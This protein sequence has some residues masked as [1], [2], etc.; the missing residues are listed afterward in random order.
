MDLYREDAGRGGQGGGQGGADEGAA[1]GRG[2]GGSQL[3]G[4]E[5]VTNVQLV[6][7]TPI[8]IRL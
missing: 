5:R 3:H 7:D 6:L 2:E 4:D 1:K 8:D